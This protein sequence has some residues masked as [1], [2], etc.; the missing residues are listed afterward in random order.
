MVTRC[1][2]GSECGEYDVEETS[3][4]EYVEQVRVPDSEICQVYLIPVM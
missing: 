3:G 4:G 1:R 2:V